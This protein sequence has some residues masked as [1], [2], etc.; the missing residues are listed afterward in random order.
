MAI[1]P[2][3]SGG[4]TGGGGGGGSQTLSSITGVL[5]TLKGGTGLNATDLGDLRQ[6]LGIANPSNPNDEYLDYCADTRHQ[7]NNTIQRVDGSTS[8]ALSDVADGLIIKVGDDQVM[9]NLA[10]GK[11]F[12][13]THTTGSTRTDWTTPV[14]ANLTELESESQIRGMADGA[15]AYTTQNAWLPQYPDNTRPAKVIIARVGEYLIA[16]AR[17]NMWWSPRPTVS[18]WTEVPWRW[19]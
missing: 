1:K 10:D 16:C 17:Y 11:Q 12:A 18:T 5:N 14:D 9:I 6:K 19:E 7:P 8:N 13:R 4:N 3:G 15:I 2:F